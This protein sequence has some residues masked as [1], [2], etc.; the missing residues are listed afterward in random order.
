[1]LFYRVL[2]G[3][4][5]YSHTDEGF[6]GAMMMGAVLMV[7]QLILIG[8][9]VVMFHLPGMAA[10]DGLRT[11]D[12]LGSIYWAKPAIMFMG[13]WGAIGGNTML[14][15]LAALTNVPQSLYEA[16]DIDGAGRFTKFWNVT[17]P[18]LAPTTFFVVVMGV[19]GGLQGG[20]EMARVMTGGGP[21][22]QTTTLSY[23][24]FTEGFETGRLA[25][26]S[27]TSWVMFFL[28]FSITLFNWKF[29]NRYVNE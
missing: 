28:V 7:G 5:L 6:G 18:Q 13:L 17:W 23:Y 20:F 16:A 8:L 11:P 1:M 27:A 19:I 4:E 3:Q 25:F 29:G 22:Q 10:D 21:A 24:I 14:L 26:A 12:W 9:A 15:Y 2:L